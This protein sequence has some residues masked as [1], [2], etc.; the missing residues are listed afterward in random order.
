[1]LSAAIS[2]RSGSSSEGNLCGYKLRSFV[3]IGGVEG[4]VAGPPEFPRGALALID[5]EAVAPGELI[6][7]AKCGLA[8]IRALDAILGLSRGLI[9]ARLQRDIRHRPLGFE[10]GAAEGD[11]VDLASGGTESA[12]WDAHPLVF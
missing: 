9:R 4:R 8:T 5:C 6:E 10:V 1:M 3:P 12:K 7:P 11:Q 2:M